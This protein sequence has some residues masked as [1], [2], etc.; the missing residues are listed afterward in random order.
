MRSAHV[1]FALL[2]A[3]LALPAGAV[4]LKLA[5]VA[6]DGTSWMKQMRAAADRIEAV[7]ED[8]YPAYWLR[9]DVAEQASDAEFMHEAGGVD[10]SGE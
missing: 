9:S 5:T 6:P 4:T 3:T 2:L 7:V 8:H 1:T 10:R